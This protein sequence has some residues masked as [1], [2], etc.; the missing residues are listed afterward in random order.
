MKST[1]YGLHAFIAGAA[2]VCSAP[3]SAQDA[4]GYW[5]GRLAVT[6]TLAL[7]IAATI[8]RGDDGVLKGT[9]DSPDQ[10]SFGIPLGE[11]TQTGD[12]LVFTVPA[13]GARYEGQWDGAA[14]A[15]KGGVTQGGNAM[16][17]VL[18]AADPATRGKP[19]VLPADWQIPGSAELGTLLEQRIA[20][21]PGAGMVLGVLDAGGQRYVARG[22]AGGAPFDENTVFEIG[23]MTKVFTALL[24]ADMAL[25]GEVALDDPVEKYLPAGAKMPSRSGK[26]ITLRMLSM[27]DSG[28]PRLPDNMQFADQADPYADYDEKLLLEFLAGYQMTRDPGETYEY[29]N[30]GVGLLGYVLARAA[31]TDFEGLVRSRIL[32]PLGMRD[33]AIALSP[34]QAARFATPHDDYMRPTKPWA[35]PTLA[36]AG[37]LRSTAKD[38]LTFVA[39]AMNPDSPIGAA[40]RLTLTDR[41]G[42]AQGAQTALG[43]MLL[44]PPSGEVQHHGGGTGGFRTHMALQPDK[45]RA[46]VVL[47]NAAPEPSAQDIAFHA[48]F[49]APVSDAAPVPPPPPVAV[50]RTEVTLSAAQLDHVVGVYELAPGVRATIRRN[51]DVLTAQITGQGAL[52]IF[53]EGPL[54][55]FYRAVD[56]QISFTEESGLVTGGTFHQNGRA[57]PIKKVE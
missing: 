45:G 35:L 52:P 51:G 14:S 27:Q 21:R 57:M 16:P 22:P 41:R 13:V 48:L 39:A 43:W 47:T 20:Q 23:S 49:G 55:F 3:A 19:V 25:K 30:L 9:L 12:R 1:R 26:A 44:H 18:T 53:P 28:L 34:A 46:V 4:A 36:G 10:N 5:E 24:L 32:D 37:A 2:I 11:V 17:L 8:K 31:G 29:S 54:A 38:M 56:A 7:R 42:S 50:E 33:T 6:P 15:W 40:M